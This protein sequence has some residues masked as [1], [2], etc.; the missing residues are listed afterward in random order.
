MTRLAPPRSIVIT[1][2]SSGLGAALARAYAAPG[3]ALGLIARN[4]TR[5][6][7]VAT[8]CRNRGARVELGLLDISE[9]TALG[10]WLEEFDRGTPI[11]LLMANAGISAGTPRD[12][13]PEGLR[14]AATQVRINLIGA[15]N[16]VEP[17]L[18]AMRARGRGRIGIVS[19]VAGL[20]GLPY[21]PGY[22]ASKAGVRAYGEGLRAL[23]RP[24]GISVSVIC[25]GF[26]DSPMTDRF[27]GS[28][29]FKLTLDA[30]AAT[31]KQGLDRGRPRIVFPRLL[32]LGLC[33]ADLMP[34][35]LGDRI[36]RHFHFHILP[37]GDM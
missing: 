26:F 2:A 34:A 30:A 4:A 1:G 36:V 29:P 20:R 9:G 7:E 5:L 12:G 11:D 15:M 35:P 33:L 6:E 14:S 28:H 23:L 3:V 27:I 13:G 22:S 31:V 19:S 24:W 21:S 10:A 32:A 18:P 16:T 8:D 17:V 37:R 25:P